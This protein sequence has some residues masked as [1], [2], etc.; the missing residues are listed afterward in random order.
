MP[1]VVLIPWLVGPLAMVATPSLV[2]MAALNFGV[3]LRSSLTLLPAHN[4]GT[5]S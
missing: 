2:A 5:R 4:H 1:L 3:R